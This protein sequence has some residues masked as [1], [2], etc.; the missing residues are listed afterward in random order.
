[1]QKLQIFSALNSPPT[2]GSH[3]YCDSP[4]QIFNSTLVIRN[5]S[6]LEPVPASGRSDFLGKKGKSDSSW[7]GCPRVY[8]SWPDFLVKKGQICDAYTSR[9]FPTQRCRF[10]TGLDFCAKSANLLRFEFA[11]NTWV[12]SLLRLPGPNRKLHACHSQCVVA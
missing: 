10:Y 7:G 8:L 1:M 5:A 6:L 12:A 9:G 4:A 3:R 11:T 2:I